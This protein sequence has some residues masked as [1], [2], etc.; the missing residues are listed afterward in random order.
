MSNKVAMVTDSTAHL[1]EEYLKQCNIS[2]TALS[3]IG[4]HTEPGTIVLNYMSGIV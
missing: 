4:T 1:P 2:V 3:V